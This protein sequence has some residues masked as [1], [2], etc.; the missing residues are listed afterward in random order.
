MK[1]VRLVLPLLGCVLLGG[2]L[3]APHTP[4]GVIRDEEPPQ[5][6]PSAGASYDPAVTIEAARRRLSR[7]PR[8]A[9]V[10]ANLGHMYLQQARRTTE[11]GYH[12]K[13][14]AALERSL[15][16][17]AGGRPP[18][19]A[20]IGMGELAN[21]RHDHTGAVRWA[22][23]ARAAA[24][25]RWA[26]Y[27]VLTDAYLQ[28]GQYDR[29]ERAL[30]RMLDGRPDLASYS[31]AARIE[32]LRGRV[33]PARELLRRAC[34][35]AADP[36][37]YASCQCQLADL[38]WDEGDPSAARAAYTLA[39]AADPG[40]VPARAGKARTEAALGD[41]DQARRDY[42]AAVARS[43][44][45]AVEYGELLDHLGDHAGARQQYAAFVAHH[46]VL[47]AN[48]ATDHYAIG[49][50]Q[51]DHGDPRTAV[52]HLRLEWARR[53]AVEVAD[54][55]AWALHRAG[56]HAEAARYAARAAA[57]GGRNALFSYHRGEIEYARGHLAW[58]R[59]HLTRALEI[60]PYF[61]PGGAVRARALLAETA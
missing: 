16:L 37:E 59:T 1:R 51:A 19:D 24:P 52:R 53:Q 56:R 27:G 28:L 7:D 34:R 60:N 44:A 61:S 9:A 30:R 57:L 21:A 31:R 20:V 11:T 46:K 3:L 23:R 42:A 26:L 10:W 47:A 45:Y 50:F 13:A 54:A 36:A 22:V 35:L 14:E 6:G 32:H 33:G 25:H 39:L 40:H 29:A 49:V 43:P 8:D 17:G 58:A 15:R 4:T 5:P 38:S 18:V 41:H 2:L 48:G 12:A 55:L